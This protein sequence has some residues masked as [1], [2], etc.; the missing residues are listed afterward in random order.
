MFSRLLCSSDTLYAYPMPGK[1]LLKIM[2]HVLASV[3]GMSQ[4]KNQKSVFGPLNQLKR[5]NKLPLPSLILQPQL[6][7]LEWQLDI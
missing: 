6:R 5:L 1:Y 7:E 4:E 3:D 2:T